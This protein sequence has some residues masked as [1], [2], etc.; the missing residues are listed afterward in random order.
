[1]PDDLTLG[2]LGR[3]LDDKVVELRQDNADL[4]RRIDNKVSLD[5]YQLQ[6]TALTAEVTT[7]KAQRAQ[8]ADRLAATRRWM[9][10]IVI[11]PL[12][13]GLLPLLFSMLGGKG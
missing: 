5:V 10:G 2:E 4:G 9:I 1:V 8:D 7:L 11:V 12:I 13:A 6:I 3:R